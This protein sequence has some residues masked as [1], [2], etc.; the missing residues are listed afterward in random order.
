M[1]CIQDLYDATVFAESVKKANDVIVMSC[2]ESYII[3]MCANKISPKDFSS[4]V[5][6]EGTGLRM[7]KSYKGYLFD[8]N[9]QGDVDCIYILRKDSNMIENKSI[10]NHKECGEYIIYYR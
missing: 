9:Y 3:T 7:V 4:T 10:W 8:D 6:Y 5:V 2:E 1:L